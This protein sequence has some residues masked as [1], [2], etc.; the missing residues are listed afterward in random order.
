MTKGYWVAHVDID[1][2]ER[3]K[4]Y[5]AANAIPFA[6]YGARF[7]VRG[8]PKEVREGQMRSRTVVI[9]FKDFAT[10]KACYDSVAYQDAKSLRDPV[11]TGDME[12]IEGYNG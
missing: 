7:L 1:D 5:V 2:M 11:S 9:E 3:Y 6:D 8:G 10:A 4:E 12:I